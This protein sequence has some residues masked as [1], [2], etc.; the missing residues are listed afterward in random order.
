[1]FKTC[2]IEAKLISPN[3]IGLP[4]FG[5]FFTIG[6][7]NWEKCDIRENKR[8]ALLSLPGLM[9]GTNRNAL[10]KGC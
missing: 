8:R 3:T 5:V 4:I 9:V 2:K 7:T 10:P 6:L 1:L